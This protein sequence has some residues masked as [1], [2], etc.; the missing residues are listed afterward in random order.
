MLI[1]FSLSR[2]FAAMSHRY[3][4]RQQNALIDLINLLRIIGAIND[5]SQ[6][7]IQLAQ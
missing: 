5:C 6:I 3:H 7:K 4:E 2:T 1:L